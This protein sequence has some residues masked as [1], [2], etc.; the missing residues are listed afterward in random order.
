MNTTMAREGGEWTGDEIVGCGGRVVRG[1]SW[2]VLN[3]ALVKEKQSWSQNVLAHLFCDLRC[4]EKGKIWGLTRGVR[5]WLARAC[6]SMSSCGTLNI[7][8]GGVNDNWTR[9]FRRLLDFHITG[10][11]RKVGNAGAS[12][13][14]DC[15]CWT[16]LER[17]VG[18]DSGGA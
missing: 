17:L 3:I 6:K 14:P 9:A 2:M 8:S 7:H 16:K 12:R 1:A 4:I 15:L 5:H 10:C 13:C 18:G 11:A